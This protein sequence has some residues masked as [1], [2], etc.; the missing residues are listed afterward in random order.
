MGHRLFP[1]RM[2]VLRL[3]E[4]WQLSCL[5]LLS[6]KQQWLA[7]LCRHVGLRRKGSWDT[8]SSPSGYLALLYCSISLRGR[9]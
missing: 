8:R 7:M 5:S 2:F 1:F 6:K 9:G 4:A 3:A